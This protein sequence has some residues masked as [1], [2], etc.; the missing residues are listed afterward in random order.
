MLDAEALRR[1]H[2]IVEHVIAELRDG[3]LTHL[4]RV[5]LAP[6]LPGSPCLAHPQPASRP[7]PAHLPVQRHRPDRNRARR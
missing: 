7:G 2:A 6:T 5:G 4:P 3:P 1:G